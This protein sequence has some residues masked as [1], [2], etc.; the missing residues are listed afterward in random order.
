MTSSWIDSIQYN[1]SSS[2]ATMTLTNGNCYDIAPMDR[3]TF[4]EWEG[5]ESGG[6]GYN[7]TLRDSLTVTKL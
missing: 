1:D 6:G 2:S 3:K 7:K 5:A 4:S